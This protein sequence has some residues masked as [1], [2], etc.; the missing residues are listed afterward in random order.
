ML[1]NARPRAKHAHSHPLS[2][3]TVGK[4]IDQGCEYLSLLQFSFWKRKARP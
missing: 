3:D 2:L 1:F 4:L